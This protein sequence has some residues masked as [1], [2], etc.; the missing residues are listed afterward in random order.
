MYKSHSN[1]RKKR[2]QDFLLEVIPRGEGG[3]EEAARLGVAP[4]VGGR[5][6][7]VPDGDP[8]GVVH[9]PV[10]LFGDFLLMGERV[11]GLIASR[12]GIHICIYIGASLTIN[13]IAIHT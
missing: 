8:Q 13:R 12:T 2:T 7:V 6:I 11:V 5:G 4:A 3:V 1:T 10:L 9:V